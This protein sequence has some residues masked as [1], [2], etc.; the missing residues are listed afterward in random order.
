MKKEELGILLTKFASGQTFLLFLKN[1]RKFMMAM[2]QAHL[3]F[4]VLF[5]EISNMRH[6]TGD[7]IM[8]FI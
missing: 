7:S 5:L 2:A 1:G 8:M 6:Y 3:E 4:I